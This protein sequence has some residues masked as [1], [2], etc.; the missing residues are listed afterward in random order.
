MTKGNIILLIIL[1]YSVNV[2][3]SQEPF[4]CD[5]NFYLVLRNGV[6]SQSKLFQIE[7]N[8]NLSEIT[9][10]ELGPDSA[11]VYLNSI[12]YRT[13]DNFIYGIDPD[14]IDLYLVDSNGKS[15]FLDK[16]E[17]LDSLKSYIAGDLSINGEYLVLV[18]GE[19]ENG[20]TTD[21][22]LIFIDLTDPEFTATRLVLADINGQ[23]LGTRVADVA[24]H[25]FNKL[26]YGF[27]QISRRMVTYDLETGLSSLE[28]FMTNENQPRTVGAIFFNEFG[29]LL[30]YGG[31]SGSTFQNILYEID[32]N[33]GL[34]EILKVGPEARGNDGCRCINIVG[35]QK[36]VL[37]TQT[38]PCSEVNYIFE[39]SNS[40]GGTLENV[41]LSDTLNKDLQFLSIDYNPFLGEFFFDSIGNVI[42]F[43]NLT[44][45]PGIDSIILTV[46]LKSTAAPGVIYNQAEMT[47]FS[48]TE[49]SIF[50]S[51]YPSTIE[52]GDPT[53]LVILDPLEA[54]ETLY[55]T[56]ICTGESLTLVSQFPN[57]E[58]VWEDFTNE[59]T[60]RITIE[61]GGTYFL[62][63]TVGCQIITE[64]FEV[65]EESIFFSLGE[66][67]F[68][69]LGEPVQLL[70]IVQSSRPFDI[71]QWMGLNPNLCL[72]C[73]S[74]SF[75]PLENQLISLSITNEAG[76]M[77]TDSV[78][79]FINRDRSVFVPNA[80]SPNGDGINDLVF[81]S[82]KIPREIGYFRI[83]N[84]WGAVVFEHKNGLTNDPSFGWDGIFKGEAV[85]TGVFIYDLLLVYPDGF[86]QQISGDITVIK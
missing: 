67:Q 12:G 73:P 78:S 47:N 50:L 60:D 24:I 72:D 79:I 13:T 34:V 75:I 22:A 7:S 52:R 5:G 6:G 16:I 69:E 53:P 11:G 64:I 46:Y 59:I 3:F 81:A 19:R 36:T 33:T 83:F 32:I 39:I 28:G 54:V 17:E 2:M 29:Q 71:F 18:E 26:L 66:D 77:D 58:Y 65:S 4:V 62:T 45:P 9:F 43:N 40:T 30:G 57:A 44:L 15:F 20:V 80:F 25:P 10:A 41:S 51:D 56:I 37:P 1:L 38:M 27:D 74:Q 31:E 70:P 21:V 61:V 49:E 86:E 84:R 48:G 14:N 42:S 82:T 85:N 8:E 68:I 76:C 63:T 23:P 55:D 35:F